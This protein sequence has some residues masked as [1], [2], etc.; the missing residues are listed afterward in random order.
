MLRP[1]PPDPQRKLRTREHVLADLSVNHVER[2][3]FR[4]AW[5]ARRMYPDYG[6]DLLMETF[7]AQG[8]F[9]NGFVLFQLKATDTLKVMARRQVIPVRLEWRDVLYWLNERDPG[10]LIIY[11]AGEERAWW[12]HLQVA[13]RAQFQRSRRP[14]VKVTLRI[15]LENRLDETAIRHFAHLRD[16]AQARTREGN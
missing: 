5:V 8:E 14:K 1:R 2:F 4:C 15:P 9:E 7:N 16:V 10:I 3:N 11:D 13:L 6:T 12:L